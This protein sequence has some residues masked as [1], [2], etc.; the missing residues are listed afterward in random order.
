MGECY[1]TYRRREGGGERGREI[2]EGRKAGREGGRVDARWM[3]RTEQNKE[4]RMRENEGLPF[5][6]FVLSLLIYVIIFHDNMI[7][8]SL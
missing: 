2:G 3:I 7:I 1:G 8:L 4:M 5:L 6:L